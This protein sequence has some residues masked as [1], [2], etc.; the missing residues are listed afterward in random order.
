MTPEDNRQQLLTRYSVLGHT[1]TGDRRAPTSI[2]VNTL[3][4][5]NEE[6]TSRLADQGVKLE[7]ITYLHHGY[8]VRRTPFSLGASFEYLLGIISLQ[9][10]A[11]QYPVQVLDPKP[12]ENVLDMCAAPGGK[13][14]Q[15]AA[16][17]MNKGAVVAL[18]SNRERLYALQNHL[19][20]T[21]VVNCAAFHADALQAELTGGYDKVLLDAPCSGNYTTDPNWL[22]K[23]T[24]RDMENNAQHQRRLLARGLELLKD[25]GVMVYSTCSLEPEENEYNMQWL[26]TNHNVELNPVSGPGS[27]GLTTVFGEELDPRIANTHRFWPDET[28]TQGFYVAEVRKL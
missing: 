25:G 4:A 27:P 14:T 18:D 24:L 11:A 7:K 5:D 16:A 22:S 20:R 12:G 26:L 9:E 13:T 28:G 2:R 15:I 17:M 21:G 10:T 8:R 6:A 1:L 23:R 19:E 3:K